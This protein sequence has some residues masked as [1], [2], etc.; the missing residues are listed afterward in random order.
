M[1]IGQIIRALR[2]E[3]GW[4]QERLALDLEMT[5]SYVSRIER[6]ERQLSTE[7]LER[8]AQALGTSVT[9]IY[10][11][12]EGRSLKDAA[13]AEKPIEIDYS[14]SG[15]KLRKL[16]RQLSEDEREL[17]IEFA[18]LLVKRRKEAAGQALD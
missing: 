6:G 5:T 14:D 13:V 15:L 17:L 1:Q 2:Q 9:G 18:R 10:A 11:L 3:K 12:A 4:S 16:F 7:L 8:M